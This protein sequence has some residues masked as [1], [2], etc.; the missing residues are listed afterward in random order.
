MRSTFRHPGCQNLSS[1]SRKRSL[2]LWLALSTALPVHAFDWSEVDWS[3]SGRASAGIGIRLQ[4]PKPSLIGKSNNDPALCR[5]DACM[6]Q[7]GDPAPNQRLVD[8]PG[9]F[10]VS[11]D[12]ANMNYQGGDLTS[13]PVRLGLEGSAYWDE[14]VFKLSGLGFYDV[15]N[16]DFTEHHLNTDFQPARVKRRA[17]VEKIVGRRVDLRDANVSGLIE[18]PGLDNPIYVSAGQQKVRWG[19]ATILLLN[20]MAEW[21]PPDVTLLTQP[22]N[23]LSDALQPIPVVT[24]ALTLADSLDL[25]LLYQ[26]QWRPIRLHP[27]GSY[28]SFNDVLDGEYF[29]VG[30]GNFPEDPNG[31]YRQPGLAEL[32]SDNSR[33]AQIGKTREP[34]DGGE[35]GVKLTWL[36]D[37]LGGAE[38]GFYYAHYHSRLPSLSAFAA[39][40]S[41]A[42]QAA[43]NSL[44][45]V[46]IACGGFDG[47]GNPFAGDGPLA[48][49]ADQFEQLISQGAFADAAELFAPLTGG[50]TNLLGDEFIRVDTMV[51]F[52]EYA[53]DIDMFGL[54]FNTTLWGWSVVGEV[55]Y[56]P[57]QPLQIS[58]R[59][60]VFAALGPGLP[61]EPIDIGPAAINGESVSTPDYL[62]IYRG[63]TIEGGDY[64]RGYERF[65]VTQFMLGGLYQFGPRNPFFADS[66]TLLPE[67]GATWINRLPALNELQISAGAPAATHF[68]AGAD[69]TGDPNG[70]ADSR[71]INPTQTTNLF[72]DPWSW[73]VRMAM[74]LDYPTLLPFDWGLKATLIG[75]WDIEGK[76]PLPIENFVEDRRQLSSIIE[77]RL[78]ANLTT[79]IGA[80]IFAGGGGASARRDRDFGSFSVSYAF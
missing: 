75:F 64:I 55:A 47:S 40:E 12:D 5:E 24:A 60:V 15:V 29:S 2:G 36:S 61:A 4:D 59:D 27:A 48:P 41:C 53:E 66:M 42:R 34:R 8:A 21:T 58:P 78:A 65:P 74:V 7:T 1:H 22:G 6:S 37:I 20:S 30:F 43:D 63:V 52:F 26:W 23:S 79:S 51:P 18:V 62:S 45:P 69:G 70:E 14:W 28:F 10:T 17:R 73:G 76:G 19:E 71:R 16:V 46:F 54:S 38:L 57:N 35:Y 50:G 72:A 13:A 11:S 68:S 25:Q 44:I 56:R 39:Q 31:D 9:L 67:V 80:T 33:T 77:V 32:S 49:L 3:I